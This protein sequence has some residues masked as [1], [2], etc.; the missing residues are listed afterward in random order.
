MKNLKEFVF[1]YAAASWDLWDKSSYDEEWRSVWVLMQIM[2]QSNIIGEFIESHPDF[3]PVIYNRRAS[4]Q[5][6]AKYIRGDNNND[7]ND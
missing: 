1:S 2:I 5:I 3:D 4:M 7:K 6:P